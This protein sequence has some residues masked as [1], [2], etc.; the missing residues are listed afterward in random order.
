V[1]WTQSE[2]LADGWTASLVTV[3]APPARSNALTAHRALFVVDG[4]RSMALVGTHNVARIVHELGGAL[5]A[6][7]EVEAIV[8]DRASTRV[9]GGWKAATSA[10]LTAIEAAVTSHVA[11]NGSDAP[12]GAKRRNVPPSSSRGSSSRGARPHS[13]TAR[14]L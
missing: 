1:L 7:T 11:A 13:A 9:L 8:Y 4:S 3:V 14:A 5:P 2:D 6:N 12:S 10:S